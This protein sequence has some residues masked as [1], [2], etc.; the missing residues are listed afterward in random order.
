[1]RLAL[2]SEGQF[3]AAFTVSTTHPRRCPTL[4]YW[5]GRDNPFT[6][7]AAHPRYD[8]YLGALLCAP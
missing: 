5:V 1:M 3:I 7:F 4:T 6:F 2:N 8:F